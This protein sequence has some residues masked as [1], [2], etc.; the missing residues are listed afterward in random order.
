M[1]SELLNPGTV[2]TADLARKHRI[3]ESNDRQLESQIRHGR[4]RGEAVE[5]LRTR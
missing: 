4:F 2:K 5:G 3:S 1:V